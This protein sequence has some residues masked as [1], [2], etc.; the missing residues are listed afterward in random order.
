MVIS[1]S[2]LPGDTLP[3]DAVA[4]SRLLVTTPLLFRPDRI[5]YFLDQ[6]RCLYE[7]DAEFVHVWI[8]TSTFDEQEKLKLM[9]LL[10]PFQST[11]FVITIESFWNPNDPKQMTWVHKRLVGD[12]FLGSNFSHFI[13]LED[14][15]RLS[16]PNMAY[17]IEERPALARHGFIPGFV[18]YEFNFTSLQLYT[19]DVVRSADYRQQS[20]SIEGKLYTMPDNPYSAAYIL[21]QDLAKEY[22]ATNSFDSERSEISCRWPSTERSAMGLCFENVPPGHLSRYKVLVNLEKLCYDTRCL[23]HHL[24]NNFTNRTW[25]EG[26]TPFG[27][28]E[29][30]K[31]FQLTQ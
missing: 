25:P 13:Y 17:F 22:I 12:N 10:S 28:L 24:P 3:R 6:I 7:F 21:D 2:M 4:R 30:L 16:R 15:I 8:I 27:K 26:H 18:R 11:R 9:R 5:I 31:V 20:I 23:I 19:S 1:D 29:L 14:D